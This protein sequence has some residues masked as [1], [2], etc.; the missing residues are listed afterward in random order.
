MSTNRRSSPPAS[1][2]DRVGATWVFNAGHQ[3]G[4]VPARIELDLD[5]GRARWVSLLGIEEMDLG[6]PAA[7][8]RTVF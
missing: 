3:I 7:A 4:P 2:A 8:A 5:E 6:A 1:W